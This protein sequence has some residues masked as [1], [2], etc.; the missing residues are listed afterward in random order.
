MVK[1]GRRHKAGTG[2][3]VKQKLTEYDPPI[4]IDKGELVCDGR[5]WNKVPR[6]KL[7]YTPPAEPLDTVV[8]MQQV[9]S[10][11]V[12]LEA[13]SEMNKLPITCDRQAAIVLGA[14]RIR[15]EDHDEM[16]EEIYR[17]EALDFD[18]V[19]NEVEVMDCDQS[20]SQSAG[21]ESDDD[22]SE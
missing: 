21:E 5:Y 3:V 15:N 2:N 4:K 6:A 13:I 7:W 1:I 11:K 14:K 17:R 12:E 16:L 8:R 9:V 19:I 18:E 10:S 22:A 20:E